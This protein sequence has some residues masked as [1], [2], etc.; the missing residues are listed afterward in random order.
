MFNKFI[1]RQS[2]YGKISNL[3]DDCFDHPFQVE[4]QKQLLTLLLFLTL[5]C[6]VAKLALLHN[7]ASS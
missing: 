3:F 4:K 5:G 6:Q 2:K 1:C 7:C